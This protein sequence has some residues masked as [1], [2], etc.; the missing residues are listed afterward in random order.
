MLLK[1]LSDVAGFVGRRDPP[2][3][4]LAEP[5]R[6]HLDQFE[7]ASSPFASASAMTSPSSRGCSVGPASCVREH[8]S[9][10]RQKQ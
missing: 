1:R 10:G 7:A 2:L 8:R 4:L 3:D 5:A 6:P 9:P